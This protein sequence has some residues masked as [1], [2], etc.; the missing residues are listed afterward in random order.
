[1]HTHVR[2]HCQLIL[3]IT[4][5]I[6]R[7]FTTI[8]VIIIIVVMIIMII[9]VIIIDVFGTCCQGSWPMMPASGS[10]QLW[11]PVLL[12][13]GVNSAGKW[14]WPVVLPNVAVQVAGLHGKSIARR[15]H[16]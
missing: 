11:R 12:S 4:I 7:I 6:T 8:I 5:T 13:C 14:W 2:M 10:D 16:S 3:T 9:I 1:M 15:V